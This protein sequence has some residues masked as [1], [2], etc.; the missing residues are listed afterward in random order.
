MADLPSAHRDLL[1]EAH[2]ELELVSDQRDRVA[3]MADEYEAER[4][5]L[6]GENARL[7]AGI[8]WVRGMCSDGEAI[9]AIDAKLGEILND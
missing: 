2:E 3:R 1:A 7:R 9:E 6:K 4:D 8:S 5:G